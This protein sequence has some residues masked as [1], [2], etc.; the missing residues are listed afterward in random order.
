MNIFF[1]LAK[2][3]RPPACFGFCEWQMLIQVIRDHFYGVRLY[4]LKRG[5]ENNERDTA[6]VAV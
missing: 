5:W 1:P 3:Q 6:A 2:Y 4:S